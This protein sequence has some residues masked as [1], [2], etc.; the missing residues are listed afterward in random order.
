MY[1]FCNVRVSVCVGFVLCECFD[2]FVGV[3]L[4]RVLVFTMF[5]IICTV[6]L[7]WGL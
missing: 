6:F 1:G 5:C 4:I 3:L 2:I 7:Y